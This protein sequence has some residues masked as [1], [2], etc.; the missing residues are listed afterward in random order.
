MNKIRYLEDSLCF[1]FDK[2]FTRCRAPFA[3]PTKARGHG[4]GGNFHYKRSL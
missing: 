1:I 2:T 3:L 4:N